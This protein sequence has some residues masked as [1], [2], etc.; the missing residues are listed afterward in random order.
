[1]KL[2]IEHLWWNV[3]LMV[4]YHSINERIPLQTGENKRLVTPGATKPTV[5]FFAAIAA[6]RR[7]V[8]GT[9]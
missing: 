1:V 4:L 8:G 6:R 3:V 7:V 2:F 5:A 9:P